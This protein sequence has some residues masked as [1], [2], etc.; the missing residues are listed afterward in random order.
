M[1]LTINWPEA[2]K[3][4]ELNERDDV[5]NPE[6]TMLDVKGLIHM[7]T[8]QSVG[9]QVICVGDRVAEEFDT[10]AALGITSQAAADA[11]PLVLMLNTSGPPAGGGAAEAEGRGGEFT[12][13]EFV[14]VKRAL[15]HLPPVTQETRHEEEKRREALAR[16]FKEG[17]KPPRARPQMLQGE[18]TKEETNAD[19]SKVYELFEKGLYGI[20]AENVNETLSVCLGKETYEYWDLR[21]P[22]TLPLRSACD[23]TDE[24]VLEIFYF[25][26]MK[27]V[28]SQDA[29]KDKVRAALSGKA[30]VRATMLQHPLRDAGCMYPLIAMPIV[31]SHADAERLG[32]TVFEHFGRAMS[33]RN[34][35]AGN[36]GKG[37]GCG[38]Q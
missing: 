23:R 4:G 2:E 32:Q 36:S 22:E 28:P 37:G 34:E 20:R 14:K 7:W 1:R 27:E 15:G 38:Q 19:K 6:S 5:L 12:H 29:F 9:S 13:E 10:L 30:G 25:G 26:E 31:V 24:I 11:A 18:Q 21:L 35:G 33:P 16:R 8:G 3:T 17:A